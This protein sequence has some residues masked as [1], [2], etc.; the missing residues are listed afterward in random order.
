[1]R[2]KAL[3]NQLSTLVRSIKFDIIFGRLRPRERLIEDDL[4]NRFSVSR[5]LVRAAFVE[6]E[7][8]GIVVR[9]PNK[10]AVVRDHT[11][12]E[13]DEIYEMRALLQA[14]A[15]RR[16]SFPGSPELIAELRKMHADYCEAVDAGDLPTVCTI[17]SLFHRRIWAS[18]GSSYLTT[19][20]ERCWTETLGIRCYGIA[21]PKLLA[22]SRQEHAE[23]IDMLERGDRA[24]F[25]K[26][27]VDHI[28]PAL[29]AY[30]RAHG[31]WDVPQNDA[32]VESYVQDDA[33]L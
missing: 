24:A 23:M 6:L 29:D 7:Q 32:F 4:V 21:D 9:R 33:F 28:W 13:I 12:R 5:H 3:D 18:C 11:M 22:R 19:M 2:K 31:S 15:A 25:E 27:S 8:L 30:K 20:L 1:M 10:G 14:E 26:L 17:N 16:M